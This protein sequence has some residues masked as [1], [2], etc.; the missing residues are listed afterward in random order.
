MTEGIYHVVGETPDKEKKAG[1]WN[2][3]I[4]LQKVDSLE[5]SEYLVALAN[6]NVNGE[7]SY[8]RVEELL[9]TRY[10]N[11][12][13]EDKALRRKES[14]LVSLRIA[15]ILDG[16]PFSL[17]P[18]SLRKI[19]GI[20]FKDIY[21]YA[22]SFRTYNISK[23]EGLLNGRSVLYTDYRN[24][25]ETLQYDCETEKQK[26]YRGMDKEAV[27]KRIAAFVSAVWQ[28]HPFGEGNTRT[29]AVFAESYLNGLGFHVNNDMFKEYSRYFR[30]ALV[31]ANYSKFAENIFADEA[32][33]EKF[34]RNLLFEGT[35]ILRSRDL[36]VW[37]CFSS[38]EQR[39]LRQAIEG[40]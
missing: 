23:R 38:E 24:I 19:H 33:L 37:E 30:N 36:F 5:P 22:G 18:D 13:E 35:E 3:A 20:L 25:R 7:L 12:T 28:V 17:N 6:R 31:R 8:R 2:A 39:Q 26:S 15:E 40:R 9:Y 4:G 29:T 21:E 1:Y 27:I 32:G 14:D 34:F 16:P 10:E 11:E